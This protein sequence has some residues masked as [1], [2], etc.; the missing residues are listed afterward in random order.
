M[1]SPARVR[2]APSPTG[3]LHIGGLRTALYNWFL[4]RQT[5]GTFL[6]RIE[7]TD[8]TRFVEGATERLVKALETCGIKPD[9]GV[10]LDA[11][12]HLIEHGSHAPYIQ[13]KRRENHLASAYELIERDHA[14]YCFC[15]AEELDQARERQI[16]GKLPQMYD[17]RCRALTKQKA[18][19]RAAVGDVHVIRLKV[20]TEGTCVFHDLIRG[21]IEVPWA[22]V[23]DQILIKSDGYPTYHLSAMCDDH[24]MEITHIVRGEE[25]ISS[26][27]KHLFLFE[28]MG[29][30]VPYF[31]HVPLLLN[32]DRSKLSKR[33]GDVAVEDYLAKGYLP[34]ALV[35]FVALLGWNPTSDREVFTK[36]E[37]AGLF[38]ITKVNKAGAMLN[39]EKLEWLNGQYLRAMT[40][41]AYLALALPALEQTVLDVGTRKRAALLFRDRATR[42]ELLPALVLPWIEAP[43]PDATLLV[44]KTQTLEEARARVASV[45]AL[46]AEWSIEQFFSLEESEACLKAWILERGWKNGEVLWPLRVA[47]SGSAQSPSPFELLFLLG[48][49]ESLKRLDAVLAQMVR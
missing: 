21:R 12:G 41:D 36:E 1:S 8:Q 7:D 4:A 10:M 47:L 40:E 49:E 14:Y 20:P 35:N 33:Q 45:R 37:L 42:V 32:A 17:R 5:S 38:D 9:E 28:A 15:T 44:W 25:W 18:E 22:Q 16:A 48:K 30:N 23:D 31:A 11:N 39:L 26:T 46:L 2:Y 6:L 43:T 27:P 24:A 34:D 29:W 13:S 3:Y 19:D